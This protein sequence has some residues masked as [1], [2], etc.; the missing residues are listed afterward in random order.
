[1]IS[2]IEA[3]REIREAI[4]GDIYIVERNQLN[5]SFDSLLDIDIVD[6]V[7]FVDD[8]RSAPSSA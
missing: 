5:T 7:S 8:E 4:V 3:H 6:G 2:A 1:L